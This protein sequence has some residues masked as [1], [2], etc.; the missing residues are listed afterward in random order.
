MATLGDDNGKT[1]DRDS[2]I[3]GLKTTCTKKWWGCFPVSHH[4]ML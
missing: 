1:Q 3:H 4:W 2:Q